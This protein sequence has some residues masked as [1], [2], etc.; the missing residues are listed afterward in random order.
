MKG[1]E[2]ST[3]PYC[4]L[5]YGSHFPDLS[6]ETRSFPSKTVMFTFLPVLGR[7]F[8]DPKSDLRELTREL[9]TCEPSEN[10]HSFRTSFTVNYMMH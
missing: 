8:D 6:F 7:K 3:F 10:C 4:N 2:K 1:R 5:T 9:S